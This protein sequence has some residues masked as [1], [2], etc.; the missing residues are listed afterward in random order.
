MRETMTIAT[1]RSTWETMGSLLA[2]L[3]PLAAVPITIITFYLRSLREHQL[4]RHADLLRRIEAVEATHRELQRAIEAVQRDY[5]T[6]QE[7]L[8]EYLHG[9]RVMEHIT[10]STTRMETMLETAGVPNAPRRLRTPTV[11]EV[12]HAVRTPTVRE[13]AERKARR[14]EGEGS[15]NRGIQGSRDRGIENVAAR[16]GNR[17]S[18]RS[19]PRLSGGGPVTCAAHAAPTAAP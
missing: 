3:A 16:I 4:S 17:L 5:T 13:R 1:F 15:R 19:G 10:R 6:K 2:V 11:S 7:W 18:A 8:R 12:P 9:R 14:D